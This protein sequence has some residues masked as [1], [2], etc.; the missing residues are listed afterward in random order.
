MEAAGGKPKQ[1]LLGGLTVVQHVEMTASYEMTVRVYICGGDG[2]GG[3]G[4][5]QNASCPTGPE[6]RE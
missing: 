4:L 1:I 6:F 3:V 2:G 5:S